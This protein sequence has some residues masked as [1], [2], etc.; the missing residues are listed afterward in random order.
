MKY[1][2]RLILPLLIVLSL[3]AA[4]FTPIVDH[5]VVRWFE[6]DVEMR[7]RLIFNTIRDSLPVLAGEISHKGMESLFNR[8]AE[9]ERVLAIGHCGRNDDLLKAS[10]LWP[11]DITCERFRTEDESVRSGLLATRNLFFAAFPMRDR[12]DVESGSLII[13]HDMSFAAHRSLKARF[14][15]MG[16]LI[17]LGVSV[18][19]ITI[20]LA[21][22]TLRRWI[23]SVH[24]SLR[25]EPREK[26][27]AEEDAELAPVI[28]EIRQIWRAMDLSGATTDGIRVDWSPDTLRRVLEVELSEAQVMVVSNREPYIHNF[29]E[30]G[31][32][33]VQ[34]PASG[35][36]TALEPVMRAC[37]GTWIAHGS[38]SA[39]QK[40]VDDG[41]RVQ[42]PPEEPLYL[43]RRIWLSEEEQAGY[44]YGLANE[45]LWPLCHIT[46]VRPVFREEDWRQ[47]QR[48][49]RRFADAVVA[50]ST[51]DDPLIL[52][53]DY[54]LALVPRLV[55]ERM[56]RATIITF[57]HIPWPNA[58]V[59][60]VCPWRKEIL[61]GLLGSSIMGFHTQLHCNNFIE[62]VDRFVECHIDRERQTIS[63]G[64]HTTRI[65]PY[66]ISIAWPPASLE[67]IHPVAQC[68]Q[69]VLE[70]F[71]L[72]PDILLGVGVER[73]DFTKGIPDRFRA[74][75]TLLE[76]HPEWIGRF[77]FLQ[78]AAPTRS[79]LPAYQ[80]IQ[81][82]AES[83]VE[84]INT[85]FGTGSWQPLLLIA[86]HHEP[87]QVYELF[88]AADLCIVSS[89]HDGMN[90]V[91]KEFVAARDDRQGV[92]ILSS[93][94][95]ASR[96]LMEALIVNPFDVTATAEAIDQALR[97]PADQQYDRMEL[98]RRLIGENNIYYW[99]G[100]LLLDASRLRKRDRIK[101]NMTR[102]A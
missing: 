15:L 10:R 93:F 57:W 89:L 22:L 44:Y 37:R 83:L 34:H 35:L 53:Q 45:G 64:Q 69:I 66:P 1:Y 3:V 58:E 92:L 72:S 73:F 30:N 56:P 9:D 81:K 54:H 100:C 20:L 49:N 13:L 21:H 25:G 8:I 12:Q 88:R 19:G 33:V 4:V 42:V 46:F 87:D 5:L 2:L 70:R 79:R 102:R 38:G 82:E 63:I 60:G 96:E 74:I 77:V 6:N 84:R 40:M 36:V 85:R 31:S 29:D 27:D 94:A 99:A 65:R 11:M 52:V 76:R 59:F 62:T 16:F 90:L 98:M 18:A 7:S 55:R 91:A 67:N 68:R 101:A 47:Y 41:D 80:E 97:M 39:D 28:S 23:K 95:G 17:I 24:R 75:E 51:R 26:D 61:L 43:L 48:V 50:E 86:R 71:N 14:Y 78:V 32:I